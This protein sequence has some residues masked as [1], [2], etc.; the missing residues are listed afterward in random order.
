MIFFEWLCHLGLES[1]D[2]FISGV[3]PHLAAPKIASPQC[4]VAGDVLPQAA[5]SIPISLYQFEER[6]LAGT[7]VLASRSRKQ[8]KFEK[9]KKQNID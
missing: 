2:Q 4:F 5:L 1:N 7:R 9:N 6:Q 8:Q 3:T